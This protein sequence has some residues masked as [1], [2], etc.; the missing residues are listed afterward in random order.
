MAFKVKKNW[1]PVKLQYRYMFWGS[2]AMEDISLERMSS[3]S[4]SVGYSFKL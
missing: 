2:K 3:V 1:I 4:L